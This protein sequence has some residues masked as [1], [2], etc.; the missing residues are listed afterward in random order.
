MKFAMLGAGGIGCYYA[1]R[2]IEA[3]HECVRMCLGALRCT[4]VARLE[5]EANIP[6][7]SLRRDALL[8]AYGLKTARKTPLG[9]AA[10]ATIKQHHHLT[11]RASRSLAV[12]LHQLCQVSGVAL[13]EVDS[14]VLSSRAPWES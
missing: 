6:P 3:G 14:V 5:V 11:N 2:L 1:A 12:R 9:I 7:L 10:S 8:L 13:D 4:R